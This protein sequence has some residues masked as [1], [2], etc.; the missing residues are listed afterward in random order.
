[1]VVSPIWSRLYNPAA[2]GQYGLVLSFLS[3][4]TVAVSLRFEYAIPIAADEGEA[5]ELVL[6]AL[7]SSIP[8][9][10]LAGAIFLT[11]SLRG[12]F[13]FGALAP[14]AALLIV[15][16]VLLSGTF[17]IFRYWHV[18][19]SDFRGIGRSLV[20][21]GF[22]RALTPI[23]FSPLNWGW[24]GLMGGEIS[25]RTFGIR[26]LGRQVI[27]LLM[28]LGRVD[29]SRL[30]RLSRKYRQYPLVFLPSSMVDALSGAHRPGRGG[31]LWV[32]GRGRILAGPTNRVRAL[33]R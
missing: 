8:M 9:S 24:L 22:A 32:D 2:F 23:L 30:G 21:Q 20:A 26:S 5:L 17:S 11:L 31:L 18:R 7:I 4:A 1:M 19:H 12:L 28:R 13:G 10:L 6:L 29:K 14:L 27:P 3:A 33:G 16:S 15:S 25:G